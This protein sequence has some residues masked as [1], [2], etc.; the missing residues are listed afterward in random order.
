MITIH[1]T[2]LM[3][4]PL[5]DNFKTDKTLNIRWLEDFEQKNRS[6]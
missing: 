3:F 2:V 6:I 5:G 4:H 1:G